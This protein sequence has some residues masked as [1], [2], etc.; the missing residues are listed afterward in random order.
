MPETFLIAVSLALDALAVSVAAGIGLKSGSRFFIVRAALFFGF[1]QFAMPCIGWFLGG[2]FADY[3]DTFDHLIAF[4]LLAIIG[5]KMIVDGFDGLNQST[6]ADITRLKPLIVLSIA[7]SID[8]L[9]V[10]TSFAMTQRGILLPSIVFGATAFALS[11]AGFAFGK[12]IGA[13]LEKAALFVG[14]A[15]LIAIGIKIALE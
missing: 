13:R 3:I 8:A 11:I 4:G 5:V 10:G 14:G 15:I 12:R 2:F 6:A 7:T 9:A 1:F